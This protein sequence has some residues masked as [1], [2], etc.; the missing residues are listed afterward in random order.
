[1]SSGIGGFTCVV[2]N[3]CP[4]TRTVL[5]QLSKT[6]IIFEHSRSAL[7]I[8]DC[9]TESFDLTSLY[10]NVPNDPALQALRAAHEISRLL[11]SIILFLF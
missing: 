1:M 2:A 11:Q 3:S 5:A 6:N 4:T 7:L 10:T 8:R 9:V